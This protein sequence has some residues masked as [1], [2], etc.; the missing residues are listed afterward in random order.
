MSFL[1]AFTRNFIEVDN[2]KKIIQDVKY[3]FNL[4]EEIELFRK[5]EWPSETESL[6]AFLE[7]FKYKQHKVNV[8][9]PI[10][11]WNW[12]GLKV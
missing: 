8:E 12:C 4:H 9:R 7:T 5:M 6:K 3:T 10:T 11:C 1:T 2:R